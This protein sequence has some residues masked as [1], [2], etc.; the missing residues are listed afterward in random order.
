[1][2]LKKIIK[3]ILNNNKT[4]LIIV[5]LSLIFS[6]WLMFSTFS[7][8]D[9]NMLIASKA[10]S[11]FASHIPLIRS[12]SF[13]NN[14]PPQYPL[15]AGPAIKYHFLFYALV[16]LLEKYGMQINFALN[17][18]SAMGFFFLM[19]MIYVFAKE[20]FKSKI[21]AFLSLIFFVFNSSLVFL[22]YFSINPFSINSLLGIISNQKFT[23]FGPY[24][25]GVISA[26]WNLNIYT[27]QRHLALSYALSLFLIYLFLK[28]KDKQQ[29]SNF[30][31]SL[32]IGVILGLSFLLNMAVFIMTVAVLGCMF[33]LFSKKRI[34]ILTSIILCA[35]ITLPQYLYIQSGVSSFKPFINPGYL[36]TNLDIYNFINYWWQNLG[37][38]LIFI[39]FGFFLAAKNERKILISFSILFIIGNLFQFSTEI[40]ANHKFFNLFIIVGAM[41]S[42]YFLHILWK[43]H[44]FFKPIVIIF[45][46]LLIFSGIIDFFPIY[47]DHLITLTDYPVNRDITWIMKNTK[48]DSVFLNTQYLYDNASL[49]GRRIYLGWPYFAWSQGYDTNI[50][51]YI[52][53][54]ILTATNKN[55]SCGLLRQNNI[56]YIEVSPIIPNADN[57]QISKTFMTDFISVYKNS[58]SEYNLLSV[59]KS[60]N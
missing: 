4:E 32:V 11:D 58:T 49:S 7:Y 1:M 8:K 33:I 18:P 44:N 37:L 29:K 17:I 26:F 20:I 22:K 56:D 52:R 12:F 35:I 25:Q 41:F 45:M 46:F 57:P 10:W 15:F 30:K 2:I 21:V 51:G 39:P 3:H 59:K 40:A 50:R 54:E 42:A 48:T 38:N 27:N 36:V 5:F 19:I 6:C 43:K 9:G 13:G 28:F 55:Y 53:N 23:S 31:K 60:C 16:G 34:Y 47:N 24:D 14:F